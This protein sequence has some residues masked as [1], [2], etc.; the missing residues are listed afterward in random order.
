MSEP[1]IQRQVTIHI[2]TTNV[3]REDV[4]ELKEYLNDNYWSWEEELN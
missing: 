4:A 1:K 3:S 2:D